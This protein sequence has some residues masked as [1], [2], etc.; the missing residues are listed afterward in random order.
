MESKK[1]SITHPDAVYDVILTRIYYRRGYLSATNALVR[2]CRG[3]DGEI[4][5]LKMKIEV[6]PFV[7]TVR[8]QF[9]FRKL[10]Q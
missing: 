7:K 5:F 1:G 8:V 2:I 6:T 10:F 9:N 3:V 4:Q